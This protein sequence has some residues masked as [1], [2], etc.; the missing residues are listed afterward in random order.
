MREGTRVT[1]DQ[2]GS[3]GTAAMADAVSEE[4]VRMRRMPVTP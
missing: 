3:G 1:A 2:G 4:V